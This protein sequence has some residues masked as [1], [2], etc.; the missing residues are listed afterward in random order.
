[1]RA[2]AWFAATTLALAGCGGDAP[3]PAAAASGADAESVEGGIDGPYPKTVTGTIAY[4]F[5][6]E[7]DSGE[8]KLALLEYEEA[9]IIVSDATYDAKGMDSEDDVEVTLTVTPIDDERCGEGDE[10]QC[11]EGK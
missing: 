4:S 3:A 7:D 9:A 10:L 2:L 11:F 1:M 5:P 8:I 6:L